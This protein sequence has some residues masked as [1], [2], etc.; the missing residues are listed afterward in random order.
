MSFYSPDKKFSKLTIMNILMVGKF[1]I[2]SDK[3]KSYTKS[4]LK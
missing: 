2:S 4:T 3:L 1:A